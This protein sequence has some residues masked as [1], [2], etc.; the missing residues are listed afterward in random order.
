M[1]H[2]AK[3][4]LLKLLAHAVDAARPDRCVPPFL[5]MPPA[6]GKI[7][8]T[9]A[10]K[11]AA[12]MAQVVEHHYRALGCLDRVYGEVATRHGY[13]LP[14]T[15]LQVREAG[16]P[17]PDAASVEAARRAL[18]LARD[19]TLA[20]LQ[21]VL[22]SGGAS[23]IWA[24][25]V[26][27]VSLEEKQA[28]TRAL[29]RGGQRI[30]AVNTVRKHLSIIKG[31]RLAGASRAGRLVTL[32][33]SDVPGDN[34][35]VI[36]SGPT[37]PDSSTSAEARAIIGSVDT[38]TEDIRAALLARLQET[39]KPGDLT[40][41]NAEYHLVAAPRLSLAAA[42]D[43][44]RD[45]GYHVD[46]LGDALEGEAREVA[47]AHAAL[48]LAR[49]SEGRRTAI[50][51]GGELTVTVRGGGTGGPNQEYALALALALA[52][53]TGISA[54]AA[55][56]DG[57]DGGSGAADDPAGAFVLPDTLARARALDLNAVNFLDDNNSSVF[58]GR[59]GDLVVTGPT[60]TNVNDF[61]VLLVDP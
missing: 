50:L 1:P 53:A 44:A 31:G 20:D 3:S 46:V 48:A 26:P 12:A 55:D 45:S 41:A 17:V 28:L 36:G 8:V 37:V 59:L 13:G 52:G 43:L 35:E 60:R 15:K 24:A 14:T 9:G 22:L 21:L 49:R 54:L 32:A 61:R 4:L 29:L 47:R 30:H 2:T 19:A 57:S 23:A 7:V 10:G 18:S 56:T 51:S 25:P 27:G 40:F 38:L 33:I 6:D 42:A 58:F 5:P 11:A 16:H 39:P 34:P